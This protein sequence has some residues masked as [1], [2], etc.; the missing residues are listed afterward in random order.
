M[1]AEFVAQKYLRSWFI[2]DFFTGI[3]V[4]S[5]CLLAGD[6]QAPGNVIQVLKILKLLRVL[7]LVKIFKLNL[8]GT[9]L[10]DIYIDLMVLFNPITNFSAI[11]FSKILR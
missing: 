4:T 2:L 10:D 8:V 11:F 3:P 1:N 9:K 5:L 6:Y 7:R